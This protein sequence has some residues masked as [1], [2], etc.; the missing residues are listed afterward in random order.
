MLRTD[1]HL[2]VL[3]PQIQ[4]QPSIQHIYSPCAILTL[5]GLKEEHFVTDDLLQHKHLTAILVP[6]VKTHI[7][8]TRL[9]SLLL[10]SALE[11]LAGRCNRRAK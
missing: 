5:A 2:H 8:V 10:L 11:A 3:I 4:L 1:M 9:N 6:M 7:W